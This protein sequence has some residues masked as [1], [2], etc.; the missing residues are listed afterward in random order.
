VPAAPAHTLR[1]GHASR[2]SYA[3]VCTGAAPSESPA[4]GEHRM[5]A[6]A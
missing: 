2:M 4:S 5:R 3:R 1:I 6:R